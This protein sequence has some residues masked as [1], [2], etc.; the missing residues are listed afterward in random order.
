MHCT[1]SPQSIRCW[2]QNPIKLSLE[3]EEI[4]WLSCM[5]NFCIREYLK[6]KFIVSPINLK[7]FKWNNRNIGVVP[8]RLSLNRLPVYPCCRDNKFLHLE[9]CFTES[10][11]GG[12]DY[13][14]DEKRTHLIREGRERPKFWPAPVGRPGSAL[15]AATLSEQ[16]TRP[17]ALPTS[18]P[19][20]TP[21]APAIPPNRRWPEAGVSSPFC[22]SAPFRF[23]RPTTPSPA[24]AGPI[25]CSRIKN[26]V[27]I[28]TS[29]GTRL[30]PVKICSNKFQVPWTVTTNE[31]KA[32]DPRNVP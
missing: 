16:R 20:P 18:A 1:Y 17:D 19:P 2:Q 6:T 21:P 29:R 27:E 7:Y 23:R 11:E 5:D 15:P 24:A 9:K 22:A 12:G 3:Y 32:F 8:F 28:D 10:S 25:P 31:G 4:L 26:H 30:W 14:R 13:L